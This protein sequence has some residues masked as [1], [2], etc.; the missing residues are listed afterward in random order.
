MVL[1]CRDIYASLELRLR[2]GVVGVEFRLGIELKKRK[3]SSLPGESPNIV[4]SH[5]AK[6]VSK[7]FRSQ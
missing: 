7:G 6:G 5:H 2:L 1:E 3:I 4:I